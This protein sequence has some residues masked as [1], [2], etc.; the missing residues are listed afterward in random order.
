MTQKTAPQRQSFRDGLKQ[1]KKDKWNVNDLKKKPEKVRFDKIKEKQGQKVDFR[2]NL[3]QIETNKFGME[4]EDEKEKEKQ[5]NKAEWANRCPLQRSQDSDESELLRNGGDRTEATDKWA[6][7]GRSVA[8]SKSHRRPRT[9]NG[10]RRA[11]RDVFAILARLG[12][13]KAVLGPARVFELGIILLC[14]RAFPPRS[15]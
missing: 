11:R 12:W 2:A 14:R 7:S 1:V 9:A 3:K 10:R 5:E 15:S 4:D 8:E 13:S 6:T